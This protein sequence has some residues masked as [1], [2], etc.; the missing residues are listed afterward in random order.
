MP[1]AGRRVFGVDRDGRA[2]VTREVLEMRIADDAE[3]SG[4]STIRWGQV[5]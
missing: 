5:H 4:A 3:P 2:G 1:A